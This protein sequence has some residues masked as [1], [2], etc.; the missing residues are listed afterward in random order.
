MKKFVVDTIALENKKLIKKG[1][2]L[3]RLG[4]YGILIS[5]ICIEIG[6]ILNDVNSDK[7]NAINNEAAD[8]IGNLSDI[9][10]E[11]NKK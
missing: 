11:Q 6:E 2:T 1:R 9:W 3:R 7:I 8:M 10:S 5:V 4:L